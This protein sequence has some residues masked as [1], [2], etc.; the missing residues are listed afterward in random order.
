MD[1][2]NWR[3]SNR[4]KRAQQAVGW[5]D[6]MVWRSK[7]GNNSRLQMMGRIVP[8]VFRSRFGNAGRNLLYALSAGWICCF[9]SERLFWTV[10]WPD[11]TAVDLV[12][13]WLAYSA[14]AYL[15]LTVVQWAAADDW[16]SMF[17]A[18]SIYGWLAEG[19]LANTLYGG[20][21]SAPFPWSISLTG[22]SWHATL[23]VFAGWWSTRRA[24]SAK[25]AWP[26]ALLCAGFGVF[27][28]VW[29]MF[30]L[31][32]TPPIEVPAQRFA[33]EA[34]G[35]TGLLALSWATLAALGLNSFR[36]GW[37]GTTLALLGVGLFYFQHAAAIGW[38]A[39]L[40]PLLLALSAG[41]LN[42]NRADRK[43]RVLLPALKANS[44]LGFVL[45]MPLFATLTFAAM[46]RSVASRCQLPLGCMELPAPLAF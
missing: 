4:A 19:G 16:A 40:L 42:L 31:Q 5:H 39:L 35:F 13:T 27:W 14:I 6:R 22:L 11:A 46:K 10:L 32:E 1:V 7:V 8:T 29:A 45:L 41:I 9:F 24:L 36:A 15:F 23:T 20:Q 43:Q 26:M 3:F 12:L 30:P 25:T 17:L 28:G 38:P 44:R 34:F 21:D 33:L 37:I 2:G 18:G